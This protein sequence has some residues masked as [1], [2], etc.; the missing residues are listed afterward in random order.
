MSGSQ[1]LLNN[2]RFIVKVAASGIEKST[3]TLISEL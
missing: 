2:K 1:F 3:V